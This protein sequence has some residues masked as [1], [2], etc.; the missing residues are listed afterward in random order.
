[1]LSERYFGWV[2]PSNVVSRLTLFLFLASAFLPAQDLSRRK[3]EALGALLEADFTR[4][5]QTL[6]APVA[7]AY[8]EA[9]VDELSPALPG[10]RHV[11]IVRKE[12]NRHHEPITLP[13]GYF[14]I[15]ASL[16]LNVKSDAEFTA[17]IAHSM[18]H[19]TARHGFRKIERGQVGQA[20]IPLIY[21][22]GW[23][24]TGDRV[25]VPERLK[26]Q[27]QAQEREA[28]SLAASALSDFPLNPGSL[29]L[30]P[31]QDEIRLLVTPPPEPPRR[32]PTL[33]R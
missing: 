21:V 26:A 23:A 9:I 30:A 2:R 3:E 28:D 4:D 32:P 13:G 19:L 22:G 10:T 14:L 8:A 16:F 24:G 6:D 31:A 12:R 20:T 1:L 11:I 5:L 17:M 25:L 15:P 7:Q 29:T 33:Y 27:L 18:A